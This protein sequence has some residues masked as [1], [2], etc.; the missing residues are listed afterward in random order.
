MRRFLSYLSVSESTVCTA[1]PLQRRGGRENGKKG[2]KKRMPHNIL[3]TRVRWTSTTI[4]KRRRESVR[5]DNQ[6]LKAQ[7]VGEKEKNTHQSSISL[8]RDSPFLSLSTTSASCFHC[9]VGDPLLVHGRTC[10]APKM[11]DTRTTSGGAASRNNKK[12]KT[13][14]IQTPTLCP[15][16]K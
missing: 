7:R 8:Q 1:R 10:L 6:Q 5:Y 13:G 9:A 12:G 4:R 11:E 14:Q 2:E 16:T 3:L 15:H